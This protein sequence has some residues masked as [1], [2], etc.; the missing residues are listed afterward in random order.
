V[1]VSLDSLSLIGPLS[2]LLI[3]FGGIVLY[4][5]LAAYRRRKWARGELQAKLEAADRRLKEGQ[6]ATR[7]KMKQLSVEAKE[8]AYRLQ[9]RLEKE[10]EEKKEI[11]DQWENRLQ[12]KER[13]LERQVKLFDDEK[14][15]LDERQAKLDERSTSVGEMEIKQRALA[16]TLQREFEKA[17][18]MS[19]FEAKQKLMASMMRDARLDLAIELKRLEG[20][21]R[22][23]AERNAKAI[24][25]QAMGRVYFD[26]VNEGT[27]STIELPDE[28]MKGRV[29]GRDGRNIRTFERIT[30]IDVIIDSTPK[31]IVL[32]GYNPHRREV[33]RIAMENLIT[34]GRIQP[35]RIEEFVEEA[36]RLIKMRMEDDGKNLMLQLELSGIHPNLLS[37]LGKLKYKFENGQNLYQHTMEVAYLSGTMAVE[38][39]VDDG[40]AKRAGL[41][42]DLGKSYDAGGEG[43]SVARGLELLRK[44]QEAQDVI[45]IVSELGA[46]DTPRSVEANLVHAADA[47]SSSRPGAKNPA[48][49]QYFR[50][51]NQLEDIAHSFKG[52]TKAY[53]IKTGT[54]LLVMAVCNQVSDEDVFWLSKDIARSIR[55]EA[56]Y[57]AKVKVIVIRETRAHAYAR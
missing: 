19:S 42:H 56:D 9:R 35:A 10:A 22:E 21:A 45:D 23:E 1:E 7:A 47:I 25:S 3:T 55:K 13:N 30:G 43:D 5:V 28:E 48:F 27:V 14:S 20:E 18:K 40:L 6:E 37:R 29:I 46:D 57:P 39:D 15:A 33:A 4:F 11:L 41:L 50:R 38:L 51:M 16:E 2:Y 52:V 31:S 17:A 32:S 8:N 54:E 53:A 36:E 26:A 49:D 24:I 34:D 44:Y 12:E